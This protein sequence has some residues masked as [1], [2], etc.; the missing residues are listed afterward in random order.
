L[1]L[2][3]SETCAHVRAQRDFK[4]LQIRDAPVMN[5]E[6]IV[7]VENSDAPVMNVEAIVIVA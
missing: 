1:I 5:V 6:A 4:A 7:I 3:D 2:N